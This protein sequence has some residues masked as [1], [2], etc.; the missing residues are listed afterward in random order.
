MR[1]NRG[2]TLIELLVVIAIIAILAAILFPVFA[3]AREKA[4]QTACLS[5]VKQLAMATLMY[6]SDWDERYCQR[7]YIGSNPAITMSLPAPCDTPTGSPVHGANSSFRPPSA[8][9][10]YVRNAGI[11]VCPSW[12]ANRTCRAAFPMPIA[13]WSYAW[14]EGSPWHTI[15]SPCRAS[16]SLGLPCQTC[17][18]ICATNANQ[19]ALDHAFGNTLSIIEAPA[20]HIMIVEFKHGNGIGQPSGMNVSSCGAGQCQDA[21]AMVAATCNNPARQTHNEG[22]NYSFWDGHAK[23]MREPDFGMWTLCASD[24]AG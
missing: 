12:S 4:R 7:T 13:R 3:K 9:Q 18:R 22:N 20:H 1:R 19:S 17:G 11:F 16:N 8:V 21:H 23:W 24:D 10:P 6:A 2:F 14:L 15:G 5:N